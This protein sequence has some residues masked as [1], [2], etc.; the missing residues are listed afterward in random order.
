M[1]RL[2]A[3]L[4]LSF[5]M[6]GSTLQAEGLGYSSSSKQ[7]GESEDYTYSIAT[8]NN[9]YCLVVQI[10]VVV[11]GSW[12]G[13]TFFPEPILKIRTFNQEVVTLK[14]TIVQPKTSYESIVG[15]DS[16]RKTLAYSMATFPVTAEDMEKIGHGISK[17]RLTTMPVNHEQSFKKDKLG[18]KLY[19]A[20]LETKAQEE[21]F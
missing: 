7:Y 5:L 21:N 6:L 16:K 17:L 15:V 8:Y 13:S 1:K 10:G 12:D 18:L 9:V 20:Y 2:F 11:N 19:Q 4:L 14:G 3:V